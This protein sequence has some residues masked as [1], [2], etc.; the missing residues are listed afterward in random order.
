MIQ[1]ATPCRLAL[2]FG[3]ER[4]LCRIAKAQ[5]DNIAG[6]LMRALGIVMVQPN[7]RW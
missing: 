2:D 3:R 7:V 5:R 6:A 1:E 4:R